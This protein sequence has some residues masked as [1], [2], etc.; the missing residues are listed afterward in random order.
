MP[1]SDWHIRPLRA[2]DSLEE[3]TEL[4]HAAYTPH[5][6]AGLR[7]VGTHQTVS[8]TADRLASGY[9]FVAEA[10]GRLVG[11]V[12]ARPPKPDSAAPLYRD[13]RTWSV[14]QLA[15][16]PQYKGRGLGR[17]LHDVAVRHAVE[18]GARTIAL[19]TAAP[20]AG[21]ISLYES[22]GY[23]IVGRVD[24][25]P[26]TNYESV[27]MARP[28][29]AAAAGVDAAERDK[30][31]HFYADRTRAC[32]FFELAP[33]ENLR[34]WVREERVAP[35]RALDLGCGNGRN[36]IFL[37][38]HGFTVDAVDYSDSAVAWAREEIARSAVAVD[39]LHG[40]VFHLHLKPGSYDFVYDSGCFH[41]MLPHQRQQYVELVTAALRS[42][43]SLGLVCF[44]PEGGSGYSDADVYERQSLGGGLGYDEARLHEIWG[45][46]FEITVLRRMHEQA[47]GSGVFGRSYLW[48][49]FGRRR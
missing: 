36:A 47:A 45:S 32:P 18:N 30:W 19:D 3:L 8:M 33:D 39:V 43:G 20:A 17:A 6:A 35:G 22:W 9:A 1:D 25:R 48:A 12:L 24:W 23:R 4:V 29:G 44:A 31:K 10:K 16:A 49:L 21:L 40:S 37:A 5:L 27:L 38:R 15:V 46:C 2:G 28:A 41:H 13:P 14:S 34:E 11:T 42:S 26:H 7:F